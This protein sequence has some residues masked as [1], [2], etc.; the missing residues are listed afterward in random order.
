VVQRAPGDPDARKKL[1]EVEKIVKRQAFEKAIS[2]DD[3]AR[4]PVSETIDVDA[5]RTGTRMTP[6]YRPF[7][8]AHSLLRATPGW[9]VVAVVEESYKG[10]RLDGEITEQFVMGTVPKPPIQATL[11]G[12]ER[13]RG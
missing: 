2:T 6:R 4:K 10:P 9:G 1:D 11:A 13:N 3:D 7:S 12:H 5:I 8:I